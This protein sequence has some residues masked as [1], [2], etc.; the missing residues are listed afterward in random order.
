[1]RVT[2]AGAAALVALLALGCGDGKGGGAGAADAGG[3]AAPDRATPPTTDVATPPMTD[4]ATP[5]ADTGDGPA[6]VDAVGDGPSSADAAGPWQGTPVTPLL[7]RGGQRLQAIYW[8]TADGAAEFRH[9]F[10]REL[11]LACRVQRADDGKTR[12]LPIPPP[13]SRRYF[14]DAACREPVENLD[15]GCTARHGY[16]EDLQGSSVHR[17]GPAQRLATV[18]SL[19]GGVGPCAVAGEAA[20][21][22]FADYGE[23]V[24]AAMFVELGPRTAEFP[25]RRVTGYYR[26]AVDGARAPDYGY[27]DNTFGRSCTPAAA[28]DG[29]LRCL[30]VTG[31]YTPTYYADDAC[32]QVLGWRAKTDAAPMFESEDLR[33]CPRA[34]RI[35]SPGADHPGPVWRRVLGG[36]CEPAPATITAALTFRTLA[37]EAPPS[38]FERLE[39]LPGTGR[40]DLRWAKSSEGTPA[41][42]GVDPVDR[43]LGT[44]CLF[45]HDAAGAWRCFPGGVGFRQ[46]GDPTCTTPAVLRGYNACGVDDP[47][48]P[49]TV[50]FGGRCTPTGRAYWPDGVPLPAHEAG[51]NGKGCAPRPTQRT[52]FG[53]KAEIP[54]ASLVQG[55]ERAF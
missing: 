46:F 17:L 10:D 26:Q 53:V 52:V 22:D 18:Y 3:D 13:S 32:T 38:Q 19:P 47:A 33:T 45:G 40:I 49:W 42:L 20:E 2:S 6:I 15:G 36:P 29:S 23:V 25:D 50:T 37:A 43:D 8:V 24:P 55:W 4:G 51:P 35:W 16:R 27:L 34:Y 48:A 39:P 7:H 41:R 14:K 9:F 30:P 28:T 31:N 5:A 54:A 44:S 21:A 12:C 1:M 11:Q